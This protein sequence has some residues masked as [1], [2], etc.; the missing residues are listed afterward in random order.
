MNEAVQQVKALPGYPSEGAVSNHLGLSYFH[1]NC[2]TCTSG[3]LR[4]LATT[5]LPTPTTPLSRAL[6]E[7]W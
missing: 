5:P 4:M 7:G 1:T 3:S 6:P 2:T